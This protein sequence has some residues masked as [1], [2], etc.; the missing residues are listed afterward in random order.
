MTNLSLVNYLVSFLNNTLSKGLV[1]ISARTNKVII[2]IPNNLV[3]EV[4][5]FLSKST[6][7]KANSLLDI[8]VV[9]YPER[10]NRF[11][12]NYLLVSVKYEIRYIIKTLVS[13]YTYI[14]SV[15]NLFPSAN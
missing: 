8:W 2:S 13:E 1:S 10:E 14:Y 9:D 3:R 15:T 7:L 6:I 12:I 5:H 4:L 11:E